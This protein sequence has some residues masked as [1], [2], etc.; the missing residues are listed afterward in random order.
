MAVLCIGL[1]AALCLFALC[2]S[3]DAEG[4]PVKTI[5]SDHVTYNIYESDDGAYAC[6]K[7]VDGEKISN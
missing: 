6:L 7:S 5:E 3:A 2:D 1:T 4:T